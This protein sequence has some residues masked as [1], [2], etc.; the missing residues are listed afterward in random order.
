M[1]D[2]QQ[3]AD[4]VT[5]ALAEDLGTGD[6]SARL[7]PLEQMASGQIIAR[8]ACTLAGIAWA[9]ATCRRVSN[10][11]ELTWHHR[12][13]DDIKA[14]EVLCTF[15][16]PARALLTAER[17]AL[18]FLQT[19]SGTA[20]TTRAYVNAVAGTGAIILDTRKTLPGL[21]LAQKY[22]VTCGGG[23]NHRLGLYDRV[24][25]KENHIMAAGSISAAVNQSRTINPDIPLEVEVENLMQLE[26]ALAVGVKLILLDNF[27]LAG[28]SAAVALNQRRAKLESSGNVDLSTVASVAQTGVDFISIG[29]LT[30]HVRA[31]DLSMR[32]N[33]PAPTGGLT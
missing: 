29:A 33:Q 7:V 20:T 28:L 30:K 10:R 3:I 18:N 26:E 31:I 23:Q 25:I 13:G 6:V 9:E 1:I 15:Q 2:S 19:L 22:A 27:D 14:G 32:F 21:R 12:D 17:T 11:I 24:L 4:D 16:G 8:E 5:R